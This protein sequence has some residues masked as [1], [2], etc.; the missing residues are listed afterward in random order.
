MSNQLINGYYVGIPETTLCSKQWQSLTPSTRC[1]YTA[2]LLKYKR[3]G[4][5]ANGRVKWKQPE[6]A[7]KAGLSL[8]TTNTCLQ[9]LKDKEWITIWEPGGRWLDGTTYE[10]N[11]SWA[12]GKE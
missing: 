6:L 12:N 5:D 11:P 1:V 3:K 2:M 7:K 9:E 4:K 10:L 8:R